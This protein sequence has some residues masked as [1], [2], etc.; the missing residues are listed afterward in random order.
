MR[1]CVAIDCVYFSSFAASVV[2]DALLPTSIAVRFPLDIM[3]NH[4]TGE[5]KGQR[6]KFDSGF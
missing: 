4:N 5:A 6:T 2:A 1:T 3:I